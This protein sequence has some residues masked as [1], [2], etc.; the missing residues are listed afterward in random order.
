MKKWGWLWQY[1]G[2]IL[3][4]LGL[5]ALLSQVPLFHETTLGSPKLRASQGVQF[6][7]FAGALMVFCQLGQRTAN[8]LSR[9]CP[10]MTFLCPVIIPLTTLIVL[11]ASHAV[12]G[13]VLN[14]F[15]GKFGKVLYNWIFVIGVV[16]AALWL[17]IAWYSKAAPL[18]QTR[19]ETPTPSSKIPGL[20]SQE[21][22]SPS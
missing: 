4:A 11:I 17:V 15:L 1:G 21:F 22:H 19:E 14:P 8:D 13:L 6:V 10:R 18:L 9:L 5:G 12:G 20:P 7:S 16:G 2:T 3:L